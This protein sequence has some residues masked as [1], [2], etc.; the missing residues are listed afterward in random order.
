VNSIASQLTGMQPSE[1]STAFSSIG[2]IFTMGCCLV[3]NLILMV[4]L[5][6]LGGYLWFLYKSKK[7]A[8]PPQQVIS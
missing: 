2:T 5:G 7:A 4:G 8:P 6:A 3:F 1:F